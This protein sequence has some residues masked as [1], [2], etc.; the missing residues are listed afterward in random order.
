MMDR[1]E[2]KSNIWYVNVYIIYTTGRFRNTN[3]NLSNIA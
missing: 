3:L 1:L 2:L